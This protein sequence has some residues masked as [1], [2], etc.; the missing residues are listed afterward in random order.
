MLAKTPAAEDLYI[1]FLWFEKDINTHNAFALM[2]NEN[3]PD[4]L[5][6]RIYIFDLWQ[7]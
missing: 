1:N 4:K 6:A 2:G 7:E 5:N 3:A